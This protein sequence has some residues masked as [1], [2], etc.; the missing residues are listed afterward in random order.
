MIFINILSRIKS[1]ILR[2]DTI[3]SLL[4]IT[5]DI[6]RMDG[7][8]HGESRIFISSKGQMN[9]YDNLKS[10]S[11]TRC[12]AHYI[13]RKVV[14][15]ARVFVEL[16]NAY[17]FFNC[18]C[19]FLFLSLLLLFFEGKHITEISPWFSWLRL[20]VTCVFLRQERQSI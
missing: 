8:T 11:F 13:K 6:T 3:L 2:S 4:I 1:M 7:S 16:K 9:A 17:F 5:S 18:S 15:I 10:K 19:V 12:F 20:K 14:P